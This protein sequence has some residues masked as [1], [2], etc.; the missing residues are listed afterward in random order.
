MS[1][2]NNSYLLRWLDL[3]ANQLLCN[4]TND[5]IPPFN[6]TGLLLS[7]CRV[8]P[9]FPRWLKTQES[10][11]WLELFNASLEGTL[12]IWFWDMNLQFL[13]TLNLSHNALLGQLPKSWSFPTTYRIDLSFNNF[14]GSA[15]LVGNNS[16]V[17]DISNNDF[18]GSLPVYLNAIFLASENKI[19]G[20]IPASICQTII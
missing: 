19:N 7:S 13:D 9:Q 8:G 18:S 3:S 10:L 12:P 6:L 5:W 17:L 14:S 2:S 4:I 15:P 20:T 16:S 11:Q 1:I